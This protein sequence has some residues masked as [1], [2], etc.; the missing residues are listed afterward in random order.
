MRRFV[1]TG[2]DLGQDLLEVRGDLFRHL[3]TVLRLKIDT[4]IT[5]TDGHGVECTG[6]IRSIG[7]E[8]LTMA[9]AERRSSRLCDSGPRITLYQ[10]LPK[11]DKMELIL[12]KCT[13]LGIAE[14]VPF[15]AERSVT[16]IPA[17][18]EVERV[19]RWRRI[20]EEAAR[21]A[22]RITVPTVRLAGTMAEAV[23]EGKHSLKLLL[24]E[25]EQGMILKR[26]LAGHPNPN[27][28][29]VIV[30]PEGGITPG[31]AALARSSG[32]IPASLGNRILRTET[33][34]IAITAILQYHYGGLGDG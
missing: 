20:A 27:G 15:A 30:G 28:I 9:L 1:V 31:E 18:R 23:R 14:V 29:A 21:Q 13:E 24:W 4:H 2:L 3:A 12:Q 5:L 33:A 22:N 32:F 26:A 25:D 8:S 11:G 17:D 10:G 6:I 19:R 16:R 7:R 34:G